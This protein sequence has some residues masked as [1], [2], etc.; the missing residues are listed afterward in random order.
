MAEPLAAGAGRLPLRMLALGIALALLCYALLLGTA[1]LSALGRALER[2]PGLLL[3]Q[4]LA[5]ALASYLLR[6]CRWQYLL[7]AQGQSVAIW[8]SLEIYLS[9]FALTLTPGK[10]GELVRSVYLLPLGV[11][12][13]RSIAAFFAERL[14][15]VLSVAL[16]ASLAVLLFPAYQYL[17]GLL[18]LGFL[19]LLLACALAWP[20][21]LLRRF[22]RPL[23]RRFPQ[24][25]TLLPF[26]L[27]GRRLA[28]TLPLG[29]WPGRRRGCCWRSWWRRWVTH[30]QPGYCLACIA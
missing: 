22:A 14:L 17:L 20:E 10:L 12:L 28:W 2:V 15:D 23:L 18:L 27:S 30:C 6:F 5:L 25:P 11:P 24:L 26:L 8:R 9:A 1:E 3:A 7:V 16:L 19:A 4:L 21:R 29:C 13:A